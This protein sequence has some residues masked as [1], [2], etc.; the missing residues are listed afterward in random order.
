MP[1]S[2]SKLRI[3]KIF[4]WLESD[5]FQ[6]D[7]VVCI[8]P[9]T[10]PAIS[11]LKVGGY[12]NHKI[13]LDDHP[14]G[15]VTTVP[16]LL[17]SLANPPKDPKFG[18]TFGLSRTSDVVLR[19]DGLGPR[20]FRIHFQQDTGCLV[21][22]DE[23]TRGIPFVNSPELVANLDPLQV[24]ISNLG[25][26]CIDSRFFRTFV[27][28]TLYELHHPE[29]EDCFDLD[30]VYGLTIIH[31]SGPIDV[32]ICNKIRSAFP[33]PKRRGNP[34]FDPPEATEF[35]ITTAADIWSLG[36]IYLRR[37]RDI[38]EVY[39]DCSYRTLPYYEY[40]QNLESEVLQ[41]SN[42]IRILPQTRQTAYE[43]HEMFERLLSEASP[44]HPTFASQGTQDGELTD[45]ESLATV[46]PYPRSSS[47]DPYDTLSP[48]VEKQNYDDWVGDDDDDE[49]E[50]R[51]RFTSPAIGYRGELASPSVSN[52]NSIT[53][54]LNS[55]SPA[56]SSTEASKNI[57]PK[58]K[59]QKI[60]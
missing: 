26:S 16:S 38:A 35:C 24:K 11:L 22:S 45:T 59:R 50:L 5:I 46:N 56:P 51:F 1:I 47:Q 19:L 44:N 30:N 39:S 4:R 10:Q 43:C 8:V 3:H 57:P 60:N 2:S 49:D 12:L 37:L 32:K 13:E 27:S 23:S 28:D 18:Y 21:F 9:L 36:M 7:A 17:L 25:D 55:G 14:D 29:F 31:K 52:F 41:E 40:L 54:V 33:P 48:P 58:A 15:P 6:D 42:M 34:I 53:G 20:H